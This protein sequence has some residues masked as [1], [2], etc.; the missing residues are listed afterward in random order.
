MCIYQAS[1]HEC[2]Q[3]R[4]GALP[5]TYELRT[6]A[7]AQTHSSVRRVLPDQGWGDGSGPLGDLDTQTRRSALAF[8]LPVQSSFPECLLFNISLVKIYG[9]IVKHLLSWLGF[10]APCRQTPTHLAAQNLSCARSQLQQVSPGPH[11]TTMTQTH[12]FTG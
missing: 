5:S 3:K 1:L 4:L 11:F 2:D 12:R 10:I 8:N 6:C 7:R 9:G